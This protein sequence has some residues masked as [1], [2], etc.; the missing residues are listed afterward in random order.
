MNGLDG[1]CIITFKDLCERPLG[2]DDY[3]EICRSFKII[4]L[5]NVPALNPILLNEARRFITFIDAAYEAKIKLLISA[6]IDLDG[7]FKDMNASN[8]EDTHDPHRRRQVRS[9]LEW[10]FLSGILASVLDAGHLG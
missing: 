3:L 2:P 4:L 1:V 6:Q 5:E 7:L 8:L 9:A 10:M